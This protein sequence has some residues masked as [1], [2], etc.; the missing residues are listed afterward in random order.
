MNWYKFASALVDLEYTKEPLIRESLH[1]VLQRILN[2]A[3]REEQWK[4]E[5]PVVE[6]R[7]RAME[8]ASSRLEKKSYDTVVRKMESDSVRQKGGFHT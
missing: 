4:D 2:M 1:F 5:I 8:T 7:L 6:E 3:K